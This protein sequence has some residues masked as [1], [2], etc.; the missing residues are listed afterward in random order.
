MGRLDQIQRGAPGMGNAFAR[1]GLRGLSLGWIVGESVKRL[2]FGLGLRRPQRVERPVISVGNV[3]AGGTGKTPFVHWLADGLRCRGRRVGILAR[4]YG[5][6]PGARLN[7]EGLLLGHPKFM[8]WETVELTP[9]T[10]ES[11]SS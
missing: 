11:T 4:G 7:D 6:A 1:L 10:S 8:G 5:R 3:V 9:A 2:A